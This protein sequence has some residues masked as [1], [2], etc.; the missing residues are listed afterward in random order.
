MHLL[1]FPNARLHLFTLLSNIVQH[2]YRIY[3]SIKASENWDINSE[4]KQP[5]SNNPIDKI[6]HKTKTPKTH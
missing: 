2:K 4:K 6:Y 3:T 1:F 5:T